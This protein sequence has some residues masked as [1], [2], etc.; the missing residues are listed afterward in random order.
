MNI[1]G[2]QL[3]VVNLSI[4]HQHRCLRPMAPIQ[5]E[6]RRGE[7]YPT[8]VPELQGLTN[9]TTQVRFTKTPTRFYLGS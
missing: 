2:N 3:P 1:R 5:A 7:G 6:L 4:A 9:D 8:K